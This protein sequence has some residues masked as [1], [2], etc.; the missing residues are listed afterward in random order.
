MNWNDDLRLELEALL[1]TAGDASASASQ[2]QRLQEILA[3][4]A[5]ARRH[6]VRY[7]ALEAQLMDLAGESQLEGS[8]KKISRPYWG[9]WA[10]AAAAACLALASYLI[11][12]P[13]N[14]NPATAE[15][16]EP[17]LEGIATLLAAQDCV[18]QGAA[19]LPG[20]DFAAGQVV[21][22]KSGSLEIVMDSG[23]HL[24][25]QGPCSLVLHSAWETQLRAG[26]VRAMV[27]E[28]AI[29]FRISSSQVDVVDLGT[30]FSISADADG[31]SAVLVH[32]GKV[33]VKPKNGP[34]R[35]NALLRT[36]QARRY[37]KDGQESDLAPE[38]KIWKNGQKMLTASK[39]AKPKPLHAWRFENGLNC[40][41]TGLA[42]A[43]TSG[44]TTPCAS[45]VGQGLHFDGQTALHTIP[46]SAAQL[47]AAMVS[48]WIQAPQ[49][50]DPATA[51]WLAWNPQLS[52]PGVLEMGFNDN[53]AH[54]TLGALALR[55][56]HK[57][58]IGTTLLR[59]G[60]WHH[61]SVGLP[62]KLNAKNIPDLHWKVY[63]DGR[64]ET[65]SGRWQEKRPK[66]LPTYAAG[67]LIG[68]DWGRQEYFTGSLDELVITD[69][70]LSPAEVCS[71]AKEQPE[72]E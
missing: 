61:I 22:L 34:P 25:M 68:C 48:F 28:E 35:K 57:H 6:Y 32:E 51:P 67:L 64:L 17:A 72:W 53:P 4:C 31:S 70:I 43:P 14:P 55:W 11:T 42:L 1:N 58:L 59:D 36:Q 29:G 15:A 54:G 62:V 7:R 23:A 46:S 8:P 45:P 63:V 60:K 3:H 69:R 47:D 21:D 50:T 41:R 44:Q 40:K 39:P 12:K 13:N 49:A 38:H 27:P 24:Q 20:Q 18:W 9:W 10:A 16:N 30:E 2:Q 71:L 33:Q 56:N 37:L 52:L 5:P 26:L 19:V 66:P 65:P